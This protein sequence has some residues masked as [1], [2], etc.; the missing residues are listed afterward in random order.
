MVELILTIV[1]MSFGV[2]GIYSAFSSTISAS[3]NISSRLT[4]AYLTQEGIEII[5]NM[6]DTNFLKNQTWSEG[7]LGCLNGCQGDY[8]TGT[9]AQ[10]AANQLS[11]Y[12]PAVFLRLNNDGFYGYDSGAPTRFTRRITINFI[13]TNTLEVNVTVF[14]DYNGKSF[15]FNAN[16][17]IYNWR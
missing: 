2:I 17:Y 5:R 14:W 12:N 16:E 7:L 11:L 8:K 6:R 15:N 3:Y 4:A 9:A 13:S 1:I 10:G